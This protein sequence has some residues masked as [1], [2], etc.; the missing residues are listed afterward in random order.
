MELMKYADPLLHWRLLHIIT[1]CWL[2][3]KVPESWKIAEVISLFKKATT[4]NVKITEK[5]TFSV[6]C[7]KFMPE[8]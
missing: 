4:E 7:T 5:L 6:R 8:L 3:Y 2:T 1:Q